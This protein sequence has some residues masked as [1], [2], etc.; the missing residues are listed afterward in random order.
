MLQSKG[1]ELLYQ[2]LYKDAEHFYEECI[3]SDPIC[4]EN[5]WYLGLTFFLEGEQLTAESVWY[6]ILL[7]SEENEVELRTSE[8]IQ[9]LDNTVTYYFQN[10]NLGIVKLLC[11]QIIGI[12]PLYFKPYFILGTVAFEQK[13]NKES[14]RYLKK[15]IEL[16]PNEFQLYSTLGGIL[17]DNLEL[18]EARIYLEKADSISSD[19][20]D[21]CTQLSLCYFLQNKVELAIQNLESFVVRNPHAG[22]MYVR[23]AGYLLI[24]SEYDKALI[25]LNQARYL[26]ASTEEV[27]L[28]FAIA[29]KGIG[30]LTQAIEYAKEAINVSPKNAESYLKLG[31]YL[32]D[33]GDIEEAIINFSKAAELDKENLA[34]HIIREINQADKAGY[35]STLR[36]G[37]GYWDPILL[38]DNDIYRLFYLTGS[39]EVVPFYSQGSMGGAI[40]RDLLSWESIGLVIETSQFHDW[41]S[42]RILSGSVYKEEGSYYFFYAASP[43]EPNILHERIGLSKSTDAI[44]WEHQ[45]D[46]FLEMNRSY[47]GGQ[48]CKYKDIMVEHI[49]WRDPFIFKDDQSLKYYMFITTNNSN[50]TGRYNACIGL[51]VAHKVDGPYQVLPPVISPTFSVESNQ[52]GIFNEMERPQIIYRNG[53]FYAFFSAAVD[54]IN[55]EWIE[56]VGKEQITSSS[57]YCYISDQ[58]AGPYYPISE[59]P[60]V[61]G[62]DKT[63]LYATN[64]IEDHNGQ[65]I[66]YGTYPSSFT[67]EVSPRFSVKWEEE[68]DIEI[69]VT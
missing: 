7:Q 5:Y 52:N 27:E 38:K 39:A 8:L 45:S 60:I 23:L 64:F 65:L 62:S 22:D 58:I 48:N 15:A 46:I 53:K 18:D 37:Y 50:K 59:K 2:G 3:K 44:H 66:A 20:A 55:P 54:K 31:S 63:K 33:R 26:N 17:R 1:I 47:Y 30:N 41:K 51:A 35:A 67:L 61:K 13:Q 24:T 9:F 12:N 69:I 36:Q 42:G 21:N 6:S 28:F 43:P 49:A 68:G 32:R 19:D 14:I 10:K 25:Y 34:E 11:N 57:L 16:N 29:N 56:K 4:R 40:S